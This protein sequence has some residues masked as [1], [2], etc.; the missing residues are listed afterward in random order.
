MFSRLAVAVQRRPVSVI[1]A[2]LVVLVAAAL[3]TLDMR[4]TASGTELLPVT[5]PQR[6][7]FDT[8]RSDYPRSPHRG[9]GC[10]P[11]R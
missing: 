3:P 5:A 6:V 1:L 2:G 7:F 9:H 11:Q 4:L 8:L 10:R